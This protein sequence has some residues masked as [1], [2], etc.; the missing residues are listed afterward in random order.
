MEADEQ[1]LSETN[2]YDNVSR[3]CAAF[4]NFT[5]TKYFCCIF[6]CTFFFLSII[7]FF[8]SA[9]ILKAPISKSRTIYCCFLGL[10]LM[11][12]AYI[13]LERCLGKR[14]LLCLVPDETQPPRQNRNGHQAFLT[15]IEIQIM[16]ANDAD[17]SA[18]SGSG[19]DSTVRSLQ[20]SG[21]LTPAEKWTIRPPPIGVTYIY[22]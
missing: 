15:D 2:F 6:A 21:Q 18:S 7:S 4:K 11:S 16:E 22:M 9:S 19:T 14:I 8:A 20:V 3:H 1:S 13:C 10:L 5:K 12:F 17:T